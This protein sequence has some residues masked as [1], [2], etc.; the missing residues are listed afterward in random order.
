MTG[1]G[2]LLLLVLAR[3]PISISGCSS[4]PP[5]GVKSLFDKYD[6]PTD[7]TVDTIVKAMPV[8]A[9]TIAVANATGILPSYPILKY[10]CLPIMCSGL[11][12]C[13]PDSLTTA[14]RLGLSTRA[15]G[16]QHS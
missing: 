13:S 8:D 16:F 6:K 11:T 3:M 1:T 7:I 14:T 5:P 9:P 15:T 4:C 2:A 10:L 12:M